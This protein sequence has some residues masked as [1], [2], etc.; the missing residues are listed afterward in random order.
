MNESDLPGIDLTTLFL[1]VSTA[2]L[3]GLGIA[4]PGSQ[5]APE[6]NLA[7]AKQN[8]DLLDLLREKTKGNRTPDE[9]RLLEQLL[10]ET[11]MLYVQVRE[12][13]VKDGAGPK[14]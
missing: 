11:R 13:N 10:Y 6:I 12:R 14:K 8:I 5:D 3:M 9:D 7:L 1:S 2:A 4:P